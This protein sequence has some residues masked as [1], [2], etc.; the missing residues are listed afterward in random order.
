M[1]EDTAENLLL[2]T[3]YISRL[4]TK[5]A[6][7][8][9]LSIT[10][11]SVLN[12]LEHWGQG[13]KL[14]NPKGTLTPKELADMEDVTQATMSNLIGNLEKEGL[15]FC[16]RSQADRRSTNVGLTK[17]GS[18]H[19]LREGIALKNVIKDILLD[20]SPSKLSK[21]QAGSHVLAEHLVV[22]ASVQSTMKQESSSRK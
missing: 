7:K 17:K 2:S 8:S 16:E 1:I 21:V 4:L 5:Q 15:V 11:F 10:A 19:L 12:N 3:V 20:L 22:S 13:P 6:K 18:K 9:Q 14:K